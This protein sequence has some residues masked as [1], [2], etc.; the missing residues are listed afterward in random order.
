[1]QYLSLAVIALLAYTFV[2][3]LV[4]LAT[5]EIPTAVVVV[6]TNAMLLTVAIALLVLSDASLLEHATDDA[7]PY[8]YGAGTA[9]TVGIIAYYYALEAGPVSVVVPV[10]GTFLVLSSLIGVVA[11]EE[12][13]TV[14][15]AAGIVLA[16]AAIWLVS[17]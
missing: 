6:V 1:M 14:R 15:K 10:F 7:A 9:L 5:N 4:S 3:P 17:T 2:A 13:F 11:L 8:M 12:E 16:G